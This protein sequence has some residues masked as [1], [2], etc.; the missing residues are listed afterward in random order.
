LSFKASKTFH[1]PPI[2]SFL[3]T[4]RQSV[5]NLGLDHTEL[6]WANDSRPRIPN[7]LEGKNPVKFVGLIFKAFQKSKGVPVKDKHLTERVEKG[8]PR[9][10]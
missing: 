2:A 3:K 4:F 9:K 6:F 5:F 1:V 8:A 10:D 7:W